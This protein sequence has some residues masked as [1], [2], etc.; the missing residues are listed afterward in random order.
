MGLER[1]LPFALPESTAAASVPVRLTGYELDRIEVSADAPVAGVL[2]FSELYYPGWKA[3][4][5]GAEQPVY[6]A[7]GCL[8]AVPVTAGTHTVILSFL[9]PPF[10]SGAWISGSTLVLAAA[11]VFLARRRAAGPA[12]GD[13]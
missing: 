7:D 5:D 8:R 4:V 12:K 3:R 9:P 1:P 13:A 11:W 6:R 10:V 2:V